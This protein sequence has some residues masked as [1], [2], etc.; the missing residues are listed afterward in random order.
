MD[1][2]L[3]LAF[4]TQQICLR[5]LSQ[6]SFSVAV[7]FIVYYRSHSHPFVDICCHIFP[8]LETMAIELS[9]ICLL[10]HRCVSLV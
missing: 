8:P 9:C 4:F 1:I 10:L 6:L 3:Q 2:F 7:L 5:D